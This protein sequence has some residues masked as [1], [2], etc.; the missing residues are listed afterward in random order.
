MGADGKA[1]SVEHAGYER[2][3]GTLT[4]CSGDM[5]SLEFLLRIAQQAEHRLR[6][7]QLAVIAPVRNSTEPVNT[8]SKWHHPGPELSSQPRRYPSSQ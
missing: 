8:E 7:T 2:N 3:D 6:P 5:H 4:G 1:M